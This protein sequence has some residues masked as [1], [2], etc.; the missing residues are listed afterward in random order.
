LRFPWQRVISMVP[1][2][3][4]GVNLFTIFTPYPSWPVSVSS[5]LGGN[6]VKALGL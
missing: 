4:V 2:D 3:P 1:L 6:I 5:L